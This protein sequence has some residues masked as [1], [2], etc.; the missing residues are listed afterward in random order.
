VGLVRDAASGQPGVGPVLHQALPEPHGFIAKVIF[1]SSSVIVK[2]PGWGPTPEQECARQV[3][4]S[5]P[6]ISRLSRLS[7]A[8]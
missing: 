5:R 8:L 7:I 4:A 1:S 3:A 2:L 6:T